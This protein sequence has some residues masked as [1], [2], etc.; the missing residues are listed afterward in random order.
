MTGPSTAAAWRPAD[1][2]RRRPARPGT[3]R[4]ALRSPAVRRVLLGYGFGA[5]GQS[6]TTV[7]V[8]VAVY[9]RTGSGGWVAA[10]AVLRYAPYVLLSGLAGVL[11]DRYDRGLVLRCSALLRA[12]LMTA[13][14]VD[15]ALGAPLAV[16][17]GSAL[18]VGVAATPAYPALV[19]AIPGLVP[20]D[21]LAAGNALVTGLEMV[22][23]VT[24]PALGG[25]LLLVA[26]A[27]VTFLLDAVLFALAAAAC[28]PVRAP[29]PAAPDHARTSVRAEL[30][31]GVRELC[32]GPGL[33]PPL[34]VAVAANALYGAS[35]VLLLLVAVRQLGTGSSGY[36]LLTVADAG[37]ALGAMA[38][39]NRLAAR[40]DSAGGLRNGLLA[41]AVPF[42]LLPLAPD[43]G[44]AALLVAVS[45]AGSTLVE[46]VAVTAIQRH[47]RPE[48]TARVFG[49]FDSAV[50]SAILLGSAVAPLLVS[51]AGL[52]AALAAVGLAGAGTAVA[53]CPRVRVAGPLPA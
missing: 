24:G 33:R 50:L 19:A 45:G 38:V 22:A 4:S 1:V 43:L 40:A 12:L 37:G 39:A 30:A 51:A 48:V 44:T 6:L 3:Y 14:A 8:A 18:L 21:D 27:P 52:P 23:F 46:V 26:P 53:A 15:I 41:G 5:V 16:L 49:L 9:D 10:A 11:A 47:V 13:V 35:L 25:L 32:T 28:W 29:L 17:A 36:G 2:R 7:A 31:D 42:L 20:D 34:V